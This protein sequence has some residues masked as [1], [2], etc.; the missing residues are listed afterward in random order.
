MRTGHTNWRNK[1]MG[2]IFSLVVFL[3][4]VMALTSPLTA[5]ADDSREN[6]GI[7]QLP[8]DYEIPPIWAVI[9]FAALL[10]CIAVLPLIDVA[11][12][13]WEENRNRLFVSL[14]LSLLVIAYYWFFHPGV[15]DHSSHSPR[16][17]TGFRAVCQV[18]DHALLSEYI[19]FIV[20]LFSL[21]VISGGIHLRGD[22]PAHPLTNTIFLA[23]GTAIASFIGTTGAAM[24]LIRPLLRTNRERIYVKHTVIFFIFLVC[25][26]GGCLLPI[27]DPPLFLG[28]LRGVP[29]LWTF[30]LWPQWLAVSIILLMVYYLWDTLAYR[31]ERRSD[32][33]Q[34]EIQ[35]Q[36]IS[37][38]GG[39]NFL[40]LLGV[41][42]S[43]ALLIPDKPL[44][45]RENWPLVPVFLREGLLVLFVVLSLVTTPRSVRFEN[46]FNYTPIVEVAI[47][48]AG[49]FITMQVPVEIL[50]V[51]GGDLQLTQPWQF[52]WATGL[53]SS[54]LDN[55]P[56]YVVFFE[57]AK[58]VT[59]DV[60]RVV[61]IP[62]ELL[63]AI[64]LGAVFMGACTYIGNGPNFMVKSIAQQNGVKMPGFFGYMLYSGAVLVPVFIAL[65]LTLR[66]LLGR[67][68]LP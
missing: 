4:V 27:G 22:L 42:M 2:N 38:R 51:R 10:L 68:Y 50:N 21:Y 17:L 64:S 1:S 44:F 30:C 32:I 43:V 33:K 54:V 28:Y 6:H 3:I 61:G 19:P 20:M 24:L 11:E 35:V 56:T 55:A 37:L 53:L 39:I 52:F 14:F 46:R 47:L 62:Q 9:P 67:W 8:D 36:K 34:D 41:V 7:H 58:T 12:Q 40:W 13:W 57:T 59:G 63:V 25:N 49:I 5:A 26:I 16:L 15:I 29:F 31:A 23:V 45:G 48:F 66:F 65:T 60:T 18:L